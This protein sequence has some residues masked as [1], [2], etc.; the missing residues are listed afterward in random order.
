MGQFGVLAVYATGP[1]YM[2]IESFN[3][4][5]IVEI[6]GGGVGDRRVGLEVGGLQNHRCRSHGPRQPAPKQ[7][8][9]KHCRET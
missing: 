9:I 4:L 3:I 2:C 6:V 8:Y 5:N 7:T 1:D